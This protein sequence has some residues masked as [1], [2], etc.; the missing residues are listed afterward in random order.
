MFDTNSNML[1]PLDIFWTPLPS[2]RFADAPQLSLRALALDHGTVR[3]P[4]LIT[5]DE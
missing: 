3:Q 5:N 2:N 1:Q 4:P